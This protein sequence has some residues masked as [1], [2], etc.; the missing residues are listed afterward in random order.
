VSE[1]GLA[2]AQEPLDVPA[3]DILGLGVDV[4]VKSK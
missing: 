1:R 2:E 4:A 3:L